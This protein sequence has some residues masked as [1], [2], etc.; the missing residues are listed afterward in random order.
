[1]NCENTEKLKL[2]FL[3]VCKYIIFYFNSYY[4]NLNN[5]LFNTYCRDIIYTIL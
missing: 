5:M 2:K 3:T 1:M 4:F